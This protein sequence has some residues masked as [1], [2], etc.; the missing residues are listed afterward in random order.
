MMESGQFVIAGLPFAAAA[1]YTD[2]VSR[3]IPNR[4]SYGG[5]LVAVGISLYFAV[6]GQTPVPLYLAFGGM[7]ISALPFFVAFLF[8]ACGGGD[9]KIMAALGAFSGLPLAID[10]SLYAIGFG[11]IFAI[12][13]LLK[14]A[15]PRLPVAV[16]GSNG[17]ES[18]GPSA[19]LKPSVPFAIPA[20]CGFATMIAFL[21]VFGTGSPWR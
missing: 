11:V 1:A 4:I 21:L 17:G 20:F 15:L 9:V 14:S 8:N 5:L 2:L 12:A 10:F 19:F 18:A 16:P 7:F 6:L 13:A 3:Q